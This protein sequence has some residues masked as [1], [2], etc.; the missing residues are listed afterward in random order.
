MLEVCDTSVFVLL[1]FFFYIVMNYTYLN[2]S[3]PEDL[4][5]SRLDS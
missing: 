1:V 5:K 3:I 2:P 4:H